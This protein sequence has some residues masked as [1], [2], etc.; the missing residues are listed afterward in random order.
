[1]EGFGIG[2]WG[3]L[4]ANNYRYMRLDMIILWLAE[5]EVELG[6]LERARELVNLIRA[7]A[8]NPDSFVPRAIQGTDRND[9]T[10]VDGEAAANYEISEYTDPWTDQATARK[11]VRLRLVWSL[12][13]K[14]IAT[15]ILC[16][17]A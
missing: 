5:A 17:G 1:M 8:A 9:F 14:D 2:G 6:D 4:T 12:P 16:V 10:I 15:G 7:R 13:W 11:A 3:N